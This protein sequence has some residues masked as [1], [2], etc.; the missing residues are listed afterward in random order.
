M[1][2][3]RRTQSMERRASC[4]WPVAGCGDPPLLD[5][6]LRTFRTRKPAAMPRILG[7]FRS[8]LSCKRACARIG[9]GSRRAP[10][11]N[12]VCQLTYCP[13]AM[14][15]R[16]SPSD[17]VFTTRLSISHSSVKSWTSGKLTPSTI[18][19]VTSLLQVLSSANSCCLRVACSSRALRF[20]ARVG[21]RNLDTTRSSA[22]SSSRATAHTVSLSSTNSHRSRAEFSSCK[23]I[24]RTATARPSSRCAMC[25]R[26]IPN[27]TAPIRARV[28]IRTK[29]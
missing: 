8:G 10:W 19:P 9:T 6:R 13:S 15:A 21:R 16:N 26:R 25:S 11:L 3:K 22:S 27:C 7:R 12:L 23:I 24:A 29:S 4:P 28:R 14:T 17:G 20:R 1:R 2:F 5:R 18:L